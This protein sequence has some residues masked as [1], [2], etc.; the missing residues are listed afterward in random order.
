[1]FLSDAPNF[2]IVAQ[3]FE[4]ESATGEGV[5]DYFDFEFEF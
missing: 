5:S 2:E 3:E 1:M 4:D